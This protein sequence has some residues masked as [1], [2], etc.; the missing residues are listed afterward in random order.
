MF[1]FSVA[2][3]VCAC[4]SAFAC[5]RT[6]GSKNASKLISPGR[7]Q[8][9]ML[10]FDTLNDFEFEWTLFFS[11]PLIVSRFTLFFFSSSFGPYSQ[12]PVNYVLME[13]TKVS[14]GHFHIKNK[15]WI[16]KNPGLTKG[17][18]STAAFNWANKE[19][20]G[21]AQWAAGN[22]Y[23]V[24]TILILAVPL[25]NLCL[26]FILF[27]LLLI[28]GMRNTFRLASRQELLLQPPFKNFN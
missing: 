13:E 11:C 7:S 18:V 21:G 15:D 1:F 9:N 20:G 3:C 19:R 4:M 22:Y 12:A 25:L 5:A 26:F 6:V 10:I 24:E 16:I 23:S 14:G 2:V 17:H 8:N 27:F 28:L